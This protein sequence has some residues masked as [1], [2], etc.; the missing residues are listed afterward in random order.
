MTSMDPDQA[1]RAVLEFLDEYWQTRGLP[2]ELG[3]ILTFSH[4]TPGQGTSDP[5]MWYDWLA[6]INAVQTGVMLPDEKWELLKPEMLKP[7]DPEQAYLAMFRYLEEYWERVKRP[8]ELDHML[9]LMRYTP[10]V[11][12]ADPALWPRWLA[13]IEKTQ[14]TPTGGVT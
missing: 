1:F 12:T 9:G 6:A 3:G 7:M 14:A 11:G 13:A 8:A 4:Y 10:G 5:A 2:E